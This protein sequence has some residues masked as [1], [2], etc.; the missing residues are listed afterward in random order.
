MYFKPLF[1]LGFWLRGL[2][3]IFLSSN[4]KYRDQQKGGLIGELALPL[5]CGGSNL[6]C[7]GSDRSSATRALRQVKEIV[8]Y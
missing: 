8:Y 5:V 3:N 2:S 1:I 7:V 4:W 6:V